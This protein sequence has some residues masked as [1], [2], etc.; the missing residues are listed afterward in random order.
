MES[1]APRI[2]VVVVVAVR[3]ADGTFAQ[4]VVPETSVVVRIVPL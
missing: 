4:E 3:P 2:V 1:H